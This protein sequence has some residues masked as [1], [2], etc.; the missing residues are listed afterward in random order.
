MK[1][2][3]RMKAIRGK[4]CERKEDVEGREYGRGR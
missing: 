3:G 4:E 2:G 1:K